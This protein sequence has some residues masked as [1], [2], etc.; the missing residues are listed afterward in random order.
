MARDHPF[1]YAELTPRMGS[2]ASGWNSACLVMDLILLLSIW[3]E[4]VQKDRITP[5][6][7]SE[8]LNFATCLL[9]SF[10]IAI[11]LIIVGLGKG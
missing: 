5:I 2:S 6:P 1:C 11:Y 10:N 4:K 9:M 7:Q 3:K 8:S